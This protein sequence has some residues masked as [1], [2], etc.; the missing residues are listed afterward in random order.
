MLYFPNNRQ[1]L[2]FFFILVISVNNYADSNALD[3]FFTQ[4]HSL[5]ADFTQTIVDSSGKSIETSSGQLIIKRPN[6]F[7]LKY[8]RPDEQH[9][10]SDG[11][12]LW[13]YDLGLE[14]VTI[15]A[16]DEKLLSSPALLI[17]SNKNINDLYDIKEISASNNSNV[18]NLVA[19]AADET[20]NMFSSIQLVFSGKQL[21]EIIMADNFDQHTRLSLYNQKSNPEINSDK[22]SF[23][24]PFGVDVIGTITD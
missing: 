13:V 18:Y 16:V 10:I 23:I 12:T 22:F 20:N 5:T 1:I 17:S 8:T 6:Q 4:T 2:A 9:Y 24:I 7:I 3:N 11:K 15:K 19:K 21:K 14:Q